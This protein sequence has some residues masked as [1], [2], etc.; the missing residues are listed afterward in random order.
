MNQLLHK[1]A[2]KN[3]AIPATSWMAF[4]QGNYLFLRER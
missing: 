2:I 3:T 1:V 4:A